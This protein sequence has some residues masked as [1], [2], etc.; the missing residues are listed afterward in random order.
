MVVPI[1]GASSTEQEGRQD[2]NAICV[3]AVALLGERLV[4]Q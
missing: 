4:P 1:P 2:L 3:A